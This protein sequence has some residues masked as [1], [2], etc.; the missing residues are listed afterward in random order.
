MD[1]LALIEAHA[2]ELHALGARRIGVFG[3]F[4]KNQATPESDVDVYV[5]FSEGMKTYDNFFALYELLRELFGRPIDLVTDGAL[6][7]R[8]ARLILPTV[9]YASLN[10]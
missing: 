5:E 8:K 10:T 3:S 9:R 1:P 2:E 6:S 4:A 7:E